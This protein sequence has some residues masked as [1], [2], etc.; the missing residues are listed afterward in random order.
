MLLQQQW[1]EPDSCETTVCGCFVCRYS[2]MKY[3]PRRWKRMHYSQACLSFHS[4]NVRRSQRQLIIWKQ[5]RQVLILVSRT[6]DQYMLNSLITSICL[7]DN[8]WCFGLFIRKLRFEN[9][10]KD[11]SPKEGHHPRK[12]VII[13]DE[14]SAA[15]IPLYSPAQHWF[16]AK[17]V[18]LWLI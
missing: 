17:K 3:I 1:L 15:P 14:D 18:W 11:I 12:D 2:H 5:P 8:I 4:C 6:L 7:C 9:W 16:L 13:R 10:R